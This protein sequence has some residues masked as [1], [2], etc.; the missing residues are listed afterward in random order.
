MP[1]ALGAFAILTTLAATP[2][3]NARTA[4]MPIMLA[5]PVTAVPF[6]GWRVSR[7][8]KTDFVL[9]ALE[10]ALHD[11]RPVQKS[12][13][14]HHSDRG[15]QYLSIRYTGRLAEVGIEPSIGSVGDS[16]DN[17]LAGT[18]NGPY[19]TELVHRQGTWRN[20]QDLEMAT[21]G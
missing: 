1:L 16:Y 12:G 7:S 13:L 3:V 14:I 8:A 18:T 4:L 2:A 20:M 19:K 9:D 6:G 11:R 5:S 10:Q 15:G 17:A 21:L